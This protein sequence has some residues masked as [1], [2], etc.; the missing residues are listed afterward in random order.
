MRICLWRYLDN[1]RNYPGY[2]L[3]A[4]VEGCREIRARLGRMDDSISIALDPP[5]ARVLAVPNNRKG[6][7]RQIAARKL[8]IQTGPSPETFHWTE[9][10]T[11]FVLTCSQKRIGDLL[12]G[13]ADIERGAGDYCIGDKRDQRLWFW[14]Q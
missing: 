7:A 3:S 14:W 11:E 10:K 9:E 2:H 8:R 13:I 1:V 6:Q 4:D 12:K 5:T